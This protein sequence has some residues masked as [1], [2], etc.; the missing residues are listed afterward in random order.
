MIDLHLPVRECWPELRQVLREHGRAVLVAP[1][2][3]GKTTLLPLLL[4]EEEWLAGRTILLLEPRRLAARMA[5]D[6]M[7][8]LLGEATGRTVGYRI[9]FE[10]LVSA[11]TRIEVLT[12]GILTR[13]LQ[14]DPALERAGLVIFD[15]FHERS[16]HGDLALA[17]CLDSVA[18]LRPDL[19]L[20]VMSATLEVEPLS[21]LLGDAPIIRGSGRAFPV[22]T[23]HLAIPERTPATPGYSFAATVRAATAAIRLALSEQ[24]GDILA[25]LPG[26]GEIRAVAAN[27]ADAA[28]GGLRVR[29]LYGELPRA[30]QDRAVLPDPEG[31]RRVVLAT[32]IAETSLTIEGVST[33]VDAGWGRVARFDPDSGLSRLVTERVSRSAA[34]QR[35]GRA[36]R[37]GPGYCYRLW[38][39]GT[40]HA[41]KEQNRPEILA[42]DLSRL[43]LE[44]ATWGVN[45]PT[46]LTWLDPPP[47][48]ALAAARELLSEL[49]ALDSRGVVTALGRKMAALP[50]HPRL[51]HLLLAAAQ[52]GQTE[53]ACDL[54]AL[55]AERDLLRNEPGRVRPADLELR[56]AALTAFRQ[57]RK[58][59][60]RALGADPELC[61]KV[62]QASR[63]F[64]RICPG[65]PGKNRPQSPGSLLAYAYPD[66]VAAL[67]PGARERYLLAS[68]RG[69][70][71][72]GDD[73]L[74]GS[75]MLVAASLDANRQ[76]GRIFLAA[77]LTIEELRT[78]HASRISK[79][80]EVEWNERDC[81]VSRQVESF[82]ML[83][84]SSRPGGLLDPEQVRTRMLAEI[85]RRGLDLLPWTPAAREL[86]ARLICLRQWQP[87]GNWPDFLEAG[88]LAELAEWLGP[89][90]TKI[91]CLDQ[92]AHLDLA[93]ILGARLDWAQ[94][95]KAD[96]LAPT[97]LEVPS[98]SRI[99]LQ[100]Q[101][102]EAPVLAVRLQELFGLGD[103][104]TVCSGTVPV[105]L[106]LLSPAKRPVQIT[107]DLRSFWNTTYKEV[108]KELQGRY[109]RHHWPDD[110]WVAPPTARIKRMER[111]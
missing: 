79:A 37:L 101:P 58:G 107:T 99:R 66:R 40:L 98:G 9:R 50:L 53:M 100:Y 78:F 41:L 34:T 93:A 10:R 108:K 1:P 39:V 27:L 60:L 12:E 35:A 64:Q 72:P 69:A 89:W 87:G 71:L 25:F 29:P 21:R 13:M 56:L 42:G 8:A 17:L 30:E 22:T 31:C 109:P 5:A 15:E 61:R 94:R 86:Q 59:E 54:A 14:D 90:L 88:L 83:E 111:K 62:D 104:P 84:L 28:S 82:L 97:H 81:L 43:A 38:D 24:R 67:R 106:H 80:P 95:Q 92:L 2:G 57:G 32:N 23:R 26:G 11:A 19:R 105:T 65:K 73:A 45:D 4:L 44:L 74:A 6:R 52:L 49:G 96:Q 91:N 103:T 18:A 63:Q 3:S 55:L 75:P 51:A 48:A 102:G 20:L 70:K 16:L 46:A 76:E 110:P 7:A 33:V 47:P 85:S 77:P 68:G 36:G